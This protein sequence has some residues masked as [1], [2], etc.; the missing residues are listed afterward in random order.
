V[1]AHSTN[2]NILSISLVPKLMSD[3]DSQS[4]ERKKGSSSSYYTVN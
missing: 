1:I 4:E 2:Y 3:K